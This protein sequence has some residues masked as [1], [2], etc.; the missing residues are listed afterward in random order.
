MA[1]VF[2]S[3]VDGSE[4]SE[5]LYQDDETVAFLDIAQATRGHTL[6]IPR[7]HRTDLRDIEPA[8]AKAVMRACVAVTDLLDR[9]LQPAGFN[10]FHATDATAWQ[11]VF[12]FHMHVVPRYSPTELQ[13]P[14]IPQP[15]PLATLRDLA[16]QIRS[17]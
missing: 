9:A 8:D 1:C 3:I 17:A 13:L 4:P 11:T 14:W 12:H 6:V 16:E 7:V 2:C 10:L 15:K 5:M